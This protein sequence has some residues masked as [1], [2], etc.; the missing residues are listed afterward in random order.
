MKRA[1]AALMCASAVLAGPARA[2]YPDRG[3]RIVVP[4]PAGQ[5]TDVLARTIGQQLTEM[6]GQSFYVD[7]RGGAGGIIG[8]EHAKRSEPD[9]YT[10]LMASSGPLAINMGLYK[11]L[12]YD[13]LRDFRAV[14][15]LVV[16]PQ[17]LVTRTDFPADT[18]EGLIKHVKSQPGKLNYGS[19]G[20]GLTNH[21]TMEML[22]REAGLNITHVPYRG[23][24]AALTGLMGGDTAMMFESGPAIMPHV[25]K[26]TLKVFAVGSRRGSQALPDVPTVD[27]A[28]VPGFDAQTWAAMLVPAGTPDEVVHK[29][30]QALHTALEKPEVRK[31]LATLGAEVQLSTPDQAQQ[32]IRDEIGRW[33]EIIKVSGAKPD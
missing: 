22:K 33:A 31:Q 27:K 13:T 12:P 26:G 16:V 30:N 1:L 14:S 32:Y 17:F 5:T 28:G 6:L 8:M 21:L 15:M 9:G 10:L 7:N 23:A 11:D 20:S 3:V 25:Q 29:L 2:D 19:G 4:F 24:A 18:L